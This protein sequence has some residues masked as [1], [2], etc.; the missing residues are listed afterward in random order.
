[1]IKTHKWHLPKIKLNEV[2]KEKEGWYSKYLSINI[3]TINQPVYLKVCLETI[4]KTIPQDFPQSEINIWENGSTMAIQG[5]VEE[6]IDAAGVHPS[7]KVNFYRHRDNIGF[8]AAHNQMVEISLGKYL[9]MLN[10]D[11][12]I[13]EQ[14]WAN[15]M[16]AGLSDTVLQVGGYNVSVCNRLNTNGH[17]F[18]V[19]PHLTEYCD[20]AFIVMDMKWARAFGPWDTD[21]FKLAY[22]EDPDL[23]LRIRALGYMIKI[24]DI[25]HIHHRA[26]TTPLIKEFDLDGIATLNRIKLL[27]RWNWYMSKRDFWV[28]IAIIRAAAAGDSLMATSVVSKIRD[29]APE[30]VIDVYTGFPLMFANNPKLDRCF[31]MNDWAGNSKKY[32]CVI[33]LNDTYERDAKELSY[34]AYYKVAGIEDEVVAWPEIYFTK[35]ELDQAD[36]IIEEHKNTHGNGRMAV[37]HTGKTNWPG[38]NLEVEKFENIAKYIQDKGW[39]V[40][41]VGGKETDKM[42][43]HSTKLQGTDVLPRISMAVISK[44]ELFIGIDSFPWNVAQTCKVPSVVGFGCINP[45]TRILDDKLTIAVQS[46]GLACLGCH[47]EYCGPV[48]ESLCLRSTNGQQYSAQCMRDI[49]VEQFTKA[50]DKILER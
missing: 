39:S 31:H 18:C 4:Y 10:D 29:L 38:R 34:R 27:N 32:H 46:E 7:F 1:V 2:E 23:S 35:E 40:I 48:H 28:R 43:I 33:N 21:V 17:G 26:K 36:K 16:I 19:P 20:G 42:N 49:S 14:D 6:A 9:C 22:C 47:H 8:A 30:A 3:V 50:V 12:E 24:I 45:K 44:G 25:A 5:I 15:K 37:F 41:E 11:M 13:Y